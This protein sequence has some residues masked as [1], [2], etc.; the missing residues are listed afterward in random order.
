MLFTLRA[1]TAADIDGILEM[2][3]EAAE[4]GGREL[5]ALARVMISEAPENRTGRPTTTFPSIVVTSPPA[6]GSRSV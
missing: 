6:G 1:A 5:C 3:Q 2:W 4:K